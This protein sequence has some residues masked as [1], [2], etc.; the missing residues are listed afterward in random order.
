[1]K[2]ELE[3]TKRIV[4]LL[5]I[6]LIEGCQ[7]VRKLTTNPKTAAELLSRQELM[8]SLLD[9]LAGAEYFNRAEKTPMDNLKIGGTD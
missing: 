5:A 6:E 4:R 2:N 1:M 3:C 9:D 7:Y 8:Q